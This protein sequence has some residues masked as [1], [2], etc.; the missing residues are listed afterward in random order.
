VKFNFD[1]LRG[2]MSRSG[3]VSARALGLRAWPSL[4][5]TFSGRCFVVGNGPS[6]KE[7]NLSALRGEIFFGVNRGYLAQA[8]GLPKPTFY[9]LSDPKT[10]RAYTEEIRAADVGLRFYRSAVTVTKEYRRSRDREFVIPFNIIRDKFIHGGDFSEDVSLGTPRGKTVVL[11]A[12]QIAVHLGFRE[13]Y[14]IGVDLS[15]PAT[16]ASHFYGTGAFEQRQLGQMPVVDVIQ[17]FA[18]ARSRIEALGGTLKNAGV[19]GNLTTLDRISYENL[20]TR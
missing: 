13:I 11:D 6:L 19:G 14:V 12:I 3:E 8:N 2:G 1:W 20:F 10:Y 15:A 18:V 4:K 5:N 17:A 16:G 7:H 9:V